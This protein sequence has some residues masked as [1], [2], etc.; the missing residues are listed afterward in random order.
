MSVP[1]ARRL[2][3]EAL[4]FSDLDLPREHRQELSDLMGEIVRS[5]R[6]PRRTIAEELARGTRR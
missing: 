6:I 5:K 3:L 1:N 4:L 2:E